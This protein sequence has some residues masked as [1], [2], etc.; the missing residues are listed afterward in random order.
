MGEKYPRARAGTNPDAGHAALRPPRAD[1]YM[2]CTSSATTSS[3]AIV[4]GV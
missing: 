4:S 1:R 2:L 3:T